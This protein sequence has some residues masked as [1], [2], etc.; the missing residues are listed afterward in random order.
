LWAVKALRDE[1]LPL[2][3][4]AVEREMKTIAEQQGPDVKLR[5]MTDGHNVIQD[6]SHTGM[7]L[8]EHTRS[9]FCARTLPPEASSP[10]E[11]PCRLDMAVGW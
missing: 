7:T 10:A 2:F 3:A 8:R 11:K 6:Y 4:T 5:Q 1:P 9:R